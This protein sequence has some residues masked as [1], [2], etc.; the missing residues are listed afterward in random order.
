MA[1]QLRKAKV[2]KAS[3]SYLDAFR[4]YRRLR[5]A[6]YMFSTWRFT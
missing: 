2:N 1:E 4:E 5:Q 3:L 6:Q